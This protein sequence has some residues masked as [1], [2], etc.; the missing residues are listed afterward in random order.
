METKDNN[1]ENIISKN[2][3]EEDYLKE[4]NINLNNNISL[5]NKLNLFLEKCKVSLNALEYEKI[6]NLL[7]SFE[8]N[9]NINIKKKIKKIINSN[10]KL[11]K[12]FEDIFE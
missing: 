11:S 10:N 5:Y 4:N 6:I 1:Y 3:N 12:L 2:S 8:I 7:K 9:S